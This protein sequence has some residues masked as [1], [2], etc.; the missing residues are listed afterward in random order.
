[1]EI[2]TTDMQPRRVNLC[3]YK[4]LGRAVFV[5]RYFSLIELSAYSNFKT[6]YLIKKCLIVLSP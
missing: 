1:M 2:T 3:F 4:G 6:V 5:S